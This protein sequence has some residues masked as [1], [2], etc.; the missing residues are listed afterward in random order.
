[1]SM[2]DQVKVGPSHLIRT[3]PRISIKLDAR[4]FNQAMKRAR[5]ALQQFA[6][7]FTASQQ[8]QAAHLGRMHTAY[9]QRARR[10]TRSRR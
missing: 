3:A 10:R 5:K 1:M 6:A 8:R 9:H 4:Q 2:L 7:G